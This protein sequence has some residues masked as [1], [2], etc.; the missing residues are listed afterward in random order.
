[1]KSS[2]KCSLVCTLLC[3]IYPEGLPS[4]RKGLI[5][6]CHLLSRDH[7]ESLSALPSSTVSEMGAEDWVVYA[8]NAPS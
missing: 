1:M 8:G 3:F 2:A 4:P 5:S 6:L 7:G